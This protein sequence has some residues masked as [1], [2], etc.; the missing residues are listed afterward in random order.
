MEQKK[1]K[2]LGLTFLFALCFSISIYFVGKATFAAQNPTVIA[3]LKVSGGTHTSAQAPR[4]HGV[5]IYSSGKVTQYKTLEGPSGEAVT[6]EIPLLRV[7]KRIA[8]RISKLIAKAKPSSLSKESTQNPICPGAPRVSYTVIKDEIEIE[9]G[10]VENCVSYA[11]TNFDLPSAQIRNMLEA[12]GTLRN[13]SQ[14]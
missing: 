2:T 10:A 6:E 5:L 4:E 14:P 3:K 9:V 13:T 1:L 7:S 12:L 8:P 11:P